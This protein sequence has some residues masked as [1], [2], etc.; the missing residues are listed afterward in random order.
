MI[1]IK[2]RVNEKGE[3]RLPKLDIFRG[4]KVSII[5]AAEDE[6][7]DLVKASESSFG[8]WENEVDEAWNTA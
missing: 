3:V 5:I 7:L 2:A 4:K 1:T 8:F 6:F